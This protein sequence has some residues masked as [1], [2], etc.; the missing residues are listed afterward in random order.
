MAILL[1]RKRETL[2]DLIEQDTKWVFNKT[3]KKYYEMGNK[4]GKLLDGI[5]KP[6]SNLNY[7]V[8]MK[9]KKGELK[10]S[11]KEVRDPAI[12]LSNAI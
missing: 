6:R 1:T 10:Y 8:K 2:R 7:I 9:D 11:T 4:T 12:I 3:S 5:I